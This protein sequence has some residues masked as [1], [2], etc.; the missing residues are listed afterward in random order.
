M[1]IGSKPDDSALGNLFFATGEG[2][3]VLPDR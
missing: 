3:D 1:V 2:E